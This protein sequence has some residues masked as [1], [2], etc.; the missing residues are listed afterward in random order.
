[1][2]AN[3]AA[4]WVS[5]GRWWPCVAVILLLSCIEPVL[6]FWIWYGAPAG[7]VPTGAHTGD[8]AH[9]VL[10]LRAFSDG[11]RSPFALDR[12][13]CPEC[14]AVPFFL[15]YAVLGEAG[16][17]LGLHEFLFLGV[18]NGVGA[19]FFL[20][21]VFAFLR[22]AFPRGATRA[23]LIFA[24][25]GGLGGI[26][27]VATGVAGLHGHAAFETA[28]FRFAVYELIEGQSLFPV[29]LMPR[30][31]YTFPLGL[32][33]GSLA[34]LARHPAGGRVGLLRSCGAGLLMA[35]ACFVNLR[36]GML[37]LAA[38]LLFVLPRHRGGRR[39]K[40]I[41]PSPLQR[42]TKMPLQQGILRE[43][44][45]CISDR[46]LL[47]QGLPFG[48]GGALGGLAGLWVLRQHPV[49]VGNV[50]LVTQATAALLPL[51]YGTVFHLPGLMAGLHAGWPRRPAVL[52]MAFGALAGYVLAYGALYLGYQAYYGNW[53]SGGD[54]TAAGAVS[55]PALGGSVIGALLAWLCSFRRRDA[56]AAESDGG[57]DRSD[58]GLSPVAFACWFLLFL[59]FSVSAFGHGWFLRFSPQRLIV[60]LGVPLSVLT[61]IGLDRLPRIAARALFALILVC[62]T[63]SIIVGSI[64][65]QGVPGQ[66]P[67]NGAF[68][69]LRYAFMSDADA[70]LLRQ[71]PPGTVAVPPWNPVSFAEIVGLH[72]GVRVIGGA[73]A[74]NLGD[75]PFHALESDV[76]SFFAEGASDETRQRFLDRYA[77]NYVLCPDTY[78]LSRTVLE[79]LRRM[80]GLAEMAQAGQGVLFEVK[81]DTSAPIR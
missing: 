56:K 80:P 78:P 28:F 65:F 10:C 70:R 41:P 60:F 32:A 44:W 37:G 14:Y 50:T 5:G 24:L 47:R 9:H 30:F 71:L 77:P 53:L 11:F 68:A 15:L 54:A 33:F 51:L 64:F 12:T 38:G 45:S 25:G 23:F 26:L 31:Y 40:N 66:R 75:R 62:G 58:S 2:K 35:G 67:G 29:P 13:P 73:G 55:D 69:Y 36:V 34:L 61:V 16:R 81:R 52:R 21:A 7:Y 6:H 18:L 79:Q 48:V 63:T 22:V 4:G 42:G 27:Y 49:Y 19:A 39:E 76:C 46:S 74:M 17:W 8:S 72:A 3:G 57:G 1:M 43:S 20:T 59:V